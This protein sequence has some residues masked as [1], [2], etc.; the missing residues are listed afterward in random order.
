MVM[1][2]LAVVELVAVHAVAKV[3]PP[4]HADLFHRLERAVNGDDIA[5]GFAHPFMQLI[6]TKRPV[7]AR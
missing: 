7:L 3:A 5:T 4:Q 1:V 2:V 6:G